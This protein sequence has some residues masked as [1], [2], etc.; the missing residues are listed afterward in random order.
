MGWSGDLLQAKNRA[1][2]AKNGVEIAFV[3][4]KEGTL[5]WFDMMAIPADA[6]HPDNAHA[7]INYLMRP[8]VIAK[9]SNVTFYA[10][11]NAAAMPLVDPAVTSDPAIYPPPEVM[12]KLF[13]VTPYDAKLQRTVTRQFSSIKGAE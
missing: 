5:M 3:V 13:V 11:G 7:F 12:A 8:E 2:E 9:A 6:P 1:I 4:P 10:N